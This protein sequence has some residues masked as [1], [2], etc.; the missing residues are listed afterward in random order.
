MISWLKN[1]IEHRTGAFG[2]IDEFMGEQIPRSTGWRNTLGSLAGALILFQIVSGILLMIFYVPHPRAAYQS[3][4]FV[5]NSITGGG[6][7]M[8]LHYWGA[9][10][11][12][13]SLFV[14]VIRVFYSG[15]YKKPREITWLVGLALFGVVLG[16]SFTG[17]L[18]PFNQAGYWAANVGIEIASA[19]PVAGPYIKSLLIGGGSL[20]ALTLTRFYAAHVVLLPLALGGLVGLHLY[21]LRRHGP[22]RPDSDTTDDTISFFPYQVL[23]DLIV[24]SVGFAALLAVAFIVGSPES[25]PADPSDTSYIPHPEWYFMSH[26]QILK[27]TPG[28]MK[29]FATFILPNLLVGALVM[30][31]WLDRSK[32]S[33][34]RKR[35]VIVALGSIVIV[36]IVVLTAYGTAQLPDQGGTHAAAGADGAYDKVVAGAALYDDFD[37]AN[38]H[39]IN[40]DGQ[41]VGPD[42]SY[43]GDRLRPDYMKRWLMNP[44]AFIPRTEMPSTKA[45]SQELN[46]LVAYLQ[47]LKEEL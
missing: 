36:S 20:G 25:G 23:R 31:P 12:V 34:W 3:L 18:L 43:V 46:E 17:Q 8:A 9:S 6:L 19:A 44:Q 10:F 26:F 13:V 33:S 35:P 22:A 1:W 47:S 15:A 38:C 21:L 16:F 2:A 11:I 7:V 37:C 39:R 32:E 24:I 42:L 45:N 27:V 5:H 30:L 4:E 41:E 28:S 14:H 29:L 40:G